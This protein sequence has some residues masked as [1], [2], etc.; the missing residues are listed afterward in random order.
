MGGQDEASDDLFERA[1]RRAWR[2]DSLLG[3]SR[4]PVAWGAEYVAKLLSGARPADLPVQ[5]PTKFELAANMKT[6]KS[7]GIT[8]PPVTM[9]QATRVI[10]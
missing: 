4:A 7:L 2:A 6:A 3:R 9:V 10:E 1:I 5:Q 8:I